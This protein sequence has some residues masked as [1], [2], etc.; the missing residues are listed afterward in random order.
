M[1][2]LAL[3]RKYRP[4][5]FYDFAGQDEITKSLLY[6]V[7][8]GTFGHCYLFSGIRGTGKTSMAK[9]F[10][11]AVNCLNPEQGNPCGVCDSCISA[12]KGLSL[13]VV[14]MDAASNNGVDDIRELR[15][16]ARF[17]PAGS[18]Y[19]VYIIDEVQMLSTSAFNALLK[20]LEEPA[21]SVIFILA[22]TELH[23]IPETILS[24]CMRYSFKR[25]EREAM[26][27]RLAKICEMEGVIYE[28][29]ALELISEHGGGA[30]RDAI[31]LMDKCFAMA[32]GNLTVKAV[33]ESLGLLGRERTHELLLSLYSGNLD[34]AIST[35]GE[36]LKEGKEIS[37]IFTEILSFLRGILLSRMMDEKALVSYLG[38]SVEKY[39]EDYR[40]I[41][42]EELLLS[43]EVFDEASRKL[44]LSNLPRLTLE[45]ALIQVSATRPIQSSVEMKKV[46]EKRQI[47]RIEEEEIPQGPIDLSRVQYYWEKLLRRLKDDSHIVI[48]AYLSAAVVEEIDDQSIHLRFGPQYRI[49]RDALM[50]RDKL[51]ILSPLIEEI[52]G[53]KLRLFAHIE[54]DSPKTEQEEGVKEETAEV[55]KEIPVAI[56]KQVKEE[57]RKEKIKDIEQEVKED[58]YL[59]EEVKAVEE[60]KAEEKIPQPVPREEPKE[61]TTDML[62][63]L[64]GEDSTK[65]VI[66]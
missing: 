41:K 57:A 17:L 8:T 43:L 13:D 29:E 46:V 18:K 64:L 31:T 15:E 37:M 10:A 6:Q 34:G 54:G 33:Q 23:K 66:K 42:E 52:F 26:V 51:E 63:R 19:K 32:R 36:I 3:Y 65:L 30:L 53:R 44:R 16:N 28:K 35:L 61:S 39:K 22:T 27:E 59:V 55:K 47:Q 24:R 1:S 11:K 25:I 40:H 38:F 20:T 14:E 49:H 58:I 9:V 60:E 50:K 45:M 21:A 62:K 7:K 4:E 12:K 2:Y 56:N 48:E 5:D